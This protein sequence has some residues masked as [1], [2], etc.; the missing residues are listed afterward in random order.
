[1]QLNALMTPEQRHRREEQFVKRSHR[2]GDDE[3][4]NEMRRKLYGALRLVNRSNPA[5]FNAF[6]A[7]TSLQ[8]L[9]FQPQTRDNTRI[10]AASGN[11]FRGNMVQL[12]VINGQSPSIALPLG[13]H[14][15]HQKDAASNAVPR[16]RPR[17]N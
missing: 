12:Q 10:V 6:S 4:D 7:S 2:V 9:G 14:L 5:M 16:A 17:N 1:M 13:S 11:V 15:G 3:N 8:N